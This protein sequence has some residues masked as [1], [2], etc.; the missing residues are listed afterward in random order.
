MYVCEVNRDNTLKI[1][2]DPS[3]CGALSGAMEAINSS[4]KDENDFSSHIIH[5]QDLSPCI[6]LYNSALNYLNI[7]T[8]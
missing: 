8:I 5:S 3:V 6:K 1:G 2:E 4:N 7:V